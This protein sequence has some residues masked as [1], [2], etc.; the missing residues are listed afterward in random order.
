MCM[1]VLPES[2]YVLSVCPWYGGSRGHWILGHQI[3]DGI[4]LFCECWA[5][6]P[7]LPLEKQVLL[8]TETSF[9]A[10]EKLSKINL[11]IPLKHNLS[12][13]LQ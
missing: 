4:G 12:N 7:G 8:S 5:L 1:N 2:T 13:Q 11:K 9:Q 10:H 6:N 3:A